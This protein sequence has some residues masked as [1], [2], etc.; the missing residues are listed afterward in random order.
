[1]LFRYKLD[2]IEIIKIRLKNDVNK[3][4]VNYNDDEQ[5]I[6]QNIRQILTNSDYQTSISLS[7][8]RNFCTCSDPKTFQFSKFSACPI[9]AH[10]K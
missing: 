9:S 8:P 2:T 3:K 1:M 6:R 7:K 10:G 4:F 5:N